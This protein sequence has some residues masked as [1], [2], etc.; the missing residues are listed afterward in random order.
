[1]IFW[2]T[3]KIINTNKISMMAKKEQFTGK[4]AAAVHTNMYHSQQTYWRDCWYH[5][6]KKAWILEAT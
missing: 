2:Y 4:A 5:R 1:M 3:G 6:S